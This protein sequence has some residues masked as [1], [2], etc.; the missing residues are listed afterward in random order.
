MPWLLNEDTAILNRLNHVRIPGDDRDVQTR[1]IFPEPETPDLTFPSIVIERA[2]AARAP[3]REHRGTANITYGPE[4]GPVAGP[5]DRWGW[6]A[7]FPIPYNIDY[8]IV[9]QMKLQAQQVALAALLGGELYL[10]ERG[11]WLEIPPRGVAVSMDIVG[12]PEFDSSVDNDGKRI[13]ELHYLVR[14]CSELTPWEIQ[15]L[16]FPDH[17]GG[18]IYNREGTNL[19]ATFDETT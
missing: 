3:D 8:S 6:Y 12:G 11:G 13:F 9:A 2:R 4:G 10:P 14:V 5:D 7:E 17:V 19:M 1:F 18:T 15:R 16:T